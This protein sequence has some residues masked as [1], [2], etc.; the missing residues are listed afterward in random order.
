MQRWHSEIFDIGIHPAMIRI[1]GIVVPVMFGSD[2]PGFEDIGVQ[3]KNPIA[4]CAKF[5]QVREW[6]TPEYRYGKL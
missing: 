4:P 6:Q 5:T 3:I 1:A 2:I